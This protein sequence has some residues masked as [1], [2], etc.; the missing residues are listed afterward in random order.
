[1][2]TIGQIIGDARAKKRLSFKRLEEITKIK[3]VF[4]ESIEKEKWQSLPP[5]PTVLGFVKS[6]S[7]PLGI[8][9]KMIIAVLKRDYPPKV[10]NIIPKPD[11]SSHFAWSPKLTF[12][13][14][15]GF[16]ILATLGYLGYQY[17]RFISS[18]G[19]TVDSPKENQIV[20]GNSVLVF[21]TT[22]TDVKLTIDDQPVLV[23]QD[24]K[25]S[26]SIGVSLSTKE[27]VIDAV[28]RSGKERI[29]SRKITVE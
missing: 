14:G 10:L 4:I 20:M 12:A 28:S 9:E 13:V 24:G 6:I 19:L 18:P 16:V 7:G 17:N 22:D 15:I 3:A 27:I 21:G 5:F 25:F 8:D 26:V 1:M 2:K 23:D 29:I 11:V